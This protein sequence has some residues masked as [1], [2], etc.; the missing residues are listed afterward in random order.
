MVEGRTVKLI[1]VED[2]QLILTCTQDA[3]TEA[4]F[5]VLPAVTGTEALELLSDT[6]GCQAM[7]LDVRLEGPLDGWEVARQ[8][9]SAQP[10]VAIIYTTTAETSD[11]E[12]HAV[13]RSVLVQKPYTLDRAVGAAFE[14]C[15][16]VGISHLS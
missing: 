4:G 12:Q 7:M 15:E 13:D 2:E 8:A 5:E 9:R 16:K 1:L 11:Y 3:L 10:D 6:P 14:A